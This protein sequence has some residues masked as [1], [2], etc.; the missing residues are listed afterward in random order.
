MVLN[1][2]KF[3]NLNDYLIRIIPIRVT[4]LFVLVDVNSNKNVIF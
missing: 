4:W 2:N 1:I 3:L